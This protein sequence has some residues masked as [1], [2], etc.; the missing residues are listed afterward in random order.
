[1]P[2]PWTDITQADPAF[3]DLWIDLLE[4]RAALQRRDIE[5]YLA[6]IDFPAGA[7]ALEVGC[8]TGAVTRIVA[9]WP[10]VAEAVGVD[11]SPAFLARAHELG[12]DVPNLSFQR[13]DGRALPFADASF[14]VVVFHSL[15][16]HVAEQERVLAEA[17]R[18]L[19]P[20]GWLAVFDGDFASVSFG[21]SDL[22]PLNTVVQGY[23]AGN[24]N[25]RF[26]VRRLRGLVAAAGFEPG[27]LRSHGLVHPAFSQ[28]VAE[29][30]VS[31]YAKQGT[32][33][34]AL[35]DGLRAET[36]RRI[37]AGTHFGFVGYAS[38]VSR[39]PG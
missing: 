33:G 32:I 29:M 24:I 18:V 1:M 22:D 23:F 8:G 21:S 26:L 5:A 11:P 17:R 25:D 37:E 35:A 20:G 36:E 13:G 27:E 15:L 30:A 4:R 3:I 10:S 34:P 31:W 16:T 2:D 28:A 14:D 7:R 39:K 38:L 6:E 19:R 9:G 12:R